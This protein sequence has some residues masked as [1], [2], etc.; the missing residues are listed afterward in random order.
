MYN[1]CVNYKQDHMS[2]KQVV[3][4]RS[5]LEA[6]RIAEQLKWNSCIDE[7]LITISI[8]EKIVR[9]TVLYK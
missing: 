5:L 7:D 3:I 4:C 9:T 2:P 8:M 1:Y 6:E